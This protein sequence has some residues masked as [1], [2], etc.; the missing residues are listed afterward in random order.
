MKSI[1]REKVLKQAVGDNPRLKIKGPM[2]F[3]FPLNGMLRGLFLDNSSGSGV[4]CP[5]VFMFPLFQPNEH[6]YFNFG[7]RLL[8]ANHTYEWNVSNPDLIAELKSEVEQVAFPFWDNGKTALDFVGMKH[9]PAHITNMPTHEAII[10][11]WTKAGRI[12][13]AVEE[14]NKLLSADHDLRPWERVIVNRLTQFRNM[15]LEEP[16]KAQLQLDE[17]ELQTKQNLKL[18]G[19]P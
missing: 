5:E 18:A 17:W 13:R 15:L 10:L 11:A 4:F 2:A 6:I 16:V 7:F 14:I 12:S 3:V 19:I 1:E 8:N 9:D